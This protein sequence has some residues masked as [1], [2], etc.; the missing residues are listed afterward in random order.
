MTFYADPNDG[1]SYAACPAATATTVKA[2]KGCLLGLW[3]APGTAVGTVTVADG[4][5]VYTT[6]PT[7]V[8]G[9]GFALAIPH[10]GI[11][12]ATSIIITTTGAGVT[13]AAFY[14]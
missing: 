8:G 5:T 12:H 2:S 11:E 3:I 7:P 9:A 4:A 6:I 13:A 14:A 1:T 10:R